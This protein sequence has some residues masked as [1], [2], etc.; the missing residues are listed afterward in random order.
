MVRFMSMSSIGERRSANMMFFDIFRFDR[1]NFNVSFSI[2][3]IFFPL[4]F[5]PINL[6]DTLNDEMI[7]NCK[8]FY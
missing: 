2:P 7:I 1:E 3:L 6:C 4:L 5:S 8:L